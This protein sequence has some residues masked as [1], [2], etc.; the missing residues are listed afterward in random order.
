[1][2]TP[3]SP[4]FSMVSAILYHAQSVYRTMS[5]WLF[6]LEPFHEPAI[7]LRRNLLYLRCG[8]RPLVDA[9]FQ[10]LIQ[11]NESVP[12][13]VQALNTVAPAT[14]EQK[15]RIRKR[16]QFKLLL[17]QSGQSVYSFSQI[18]VAA[19]DVHLICTGEVI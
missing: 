9:L 7:L 6:H 14:A 11:K 12:L 17:Y 10:P 2:K 3:K 13:P 8:S 15:Q 4:V 5:F 1:M 19:G 18:R 16:I